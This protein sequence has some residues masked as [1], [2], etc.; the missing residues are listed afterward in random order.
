[1]HV[2]G[3]YVFVTRKAEE[4]MHYIVETPLMIHDRSHNRCNFFSF[5]LF[6]FALS[7]NIDTWS[8]RLCVYLHMYISGV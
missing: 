5:L 4:V 8:D 6:I 1:M 3:V 2:Y 7:I